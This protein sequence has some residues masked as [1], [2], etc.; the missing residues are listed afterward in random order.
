MKIKLA[1]RARHWAPW[2]LITLASISTKA[3]SA[4]ELTCPS[5]FLAD[6]KFNPIIRFL[7]PLEGQY[8]IGSCKVE[9][10]VCRPP[11]SNSQQTDQ[12][13]AADVLV[14]DHHGFQRYVPIYFL[15]Q[16][17]EKVAF[18][19]RIFRRA[20]HYTFHDE[21]R[22]PSTGRYEFSRMEI[23]KTSNLKSIETIEIGYWTQ[24]EKRQHLGKAWITCGGI[25]DDALVEKRGY[26]ICES[27]M[28]ENCFYHV[29]QTNQ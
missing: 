29:R 23:D 16:E 3:D 28:Q 22:N 24:V 19:P 18:L 11:K 2:V 25:N 8:R 21:N 12:A 15:S 20:F 13:L 6:S 9:I 4:N 10:H 14:T 5:A 7:G 17:T 1:S 26:E 27:P